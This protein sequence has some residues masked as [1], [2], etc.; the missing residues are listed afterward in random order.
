[1]LYATDYL[2]RIEAGLRSALPR[3]GIPDGSRLRLLTISENATYIVDHPDGMR[4]VFRVNRPGYHTRA[5]ILSELEWTQVLH[6]A[7]IVNTPRLLPG[8][9]GAPLR[10]FQVGADERYAMCFEYIDGVEPDADSDLPGWFRHLGAMTARLH[11]HSRGFAPSAGF[12]RKRWCFE[13]IIGPD[14]YWGDWRAHPDLSSDGRAL[15]ERAA[16]RLRD[17]L[18]AFGTGPERFGLIHGDMRAANL[19]VQG[20]RLWV[21]DFDDCGFS[22]FGYDFAASISFIEHR[23]DIPDLRAAWI[24]GYDT[25]AALDTASLAMLDDFVVLRRMQLT[26]WL[27]THAE[28]PTAAMVGPGY[29]AGTVAIAQAWLDS[30]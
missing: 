24:A 22:W 26:A 28:T 5:E 16:A 25:V 18:A 4:V 29:A 10:R 9:D 21:I 17:R 1:M 13:T 19:I 30:V 15:L 6:A 23:P 20:D 12:V 14:A 8:L 11:A 3:W 7:A 27:A 2:A